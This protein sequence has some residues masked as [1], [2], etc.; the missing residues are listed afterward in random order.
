MAQDL[1]TRTGGG[2]KLVVSGGGTGGHVYPAL[3]VIDTLLKP[4]GPQGTTPV[5]EQ[6]D[7][8]WIGSRGGM[9]EGLVARADIEFVG[10]PAGG[11]R[12]MGLAMGTR[13]SV[14]ILRSAGTA[15]RILTGFGT[16]VVFITGGYAS[17]SVA[18]AAWTKR[19]PIVIYLPDIVPGM[20]IRYLSRLA[21]R[22]AVTSEESYRFFPRD[23]VVVTGYPVRDEVLSLNREEAREGLGLEHDVKTL[24]VFGGSRGARSINR[25]AVA[26]LRELLPL[27][28]IVHITG[29]LD[30][31]WVTGAAKSL[32]EELRVRY[33]QYDYLHD[34]PQALVAADLVVARAGA[35]TLGEFPAAG[36]PAVLVP[37]PHSGQHQQPNALYMAASGAAELLPDAALDDELVP[38][39][40]A[41]LED[42]T[43]W[44]NM[45]QAARAMARPDA[46]ESIA[47]L[48]WQVRR[49]R[50]TERPAGGAA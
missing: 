21:T 39:V 17:V 28:Q 47:K 44:D 49:Q 33:H 14:R 29:P 34:M 6:R 46:A 48:L 20:A 12:G 40:R 7:L 37:Y 42:E 9:E 16:N 3:T 43:R 19:L 4:G 15:R 18:L 8:L 35:A 13:N 45:R 27:C 10:L 31:S 23:K 30:A 41:L 11:V 22:I 5:L 1:S 2:V 36:L 50:N 25:A 24:L 26:G 32:P 38:T